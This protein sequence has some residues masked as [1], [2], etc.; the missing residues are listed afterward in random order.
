VARLQKIISEDRSQKIS[1]LDEEIRIG[2]GICQRILVAEFAMNCV[3]A[4]F[5]SRF[6][7]ADQKKQRVSI[8]EE[9]H[10]VASDKETFFPRVVTGDECWIY[11]YD[12]EAKQQS[13]Q[14]RKSKF[15]ETEK[16]R[17]K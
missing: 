14:R 15:T 6:L 3:A 11:G 16:G 9:L 17:E 13:S 5:V 4:K 8:W 2:Y 1:D 12:P 10:Q 7:T